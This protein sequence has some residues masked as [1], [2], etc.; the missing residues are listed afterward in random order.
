MD[1]SSFQ[2]SFLTLGKK[3][4]SNNIWTGAAIIRQ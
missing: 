4:D 3:H 2:V 1:R